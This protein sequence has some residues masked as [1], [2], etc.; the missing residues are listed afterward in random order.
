[1]VF[2]SSTF[3]SLRNIHSNHQRYDTFARVTWNQILL[4]FVPFPVLLNR[5]SW[6][7]SSIF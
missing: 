6:S 7:S 2:S 4:Y 5:R 1:V 3:T